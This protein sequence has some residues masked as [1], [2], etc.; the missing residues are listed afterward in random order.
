[1]DDQAIVD[2]PA[3]VAGLAFFW[4]LSRGICLALRKGLQEKVNMNAY[5]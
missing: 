1:M 5:E 4:Y 2:G 3:C